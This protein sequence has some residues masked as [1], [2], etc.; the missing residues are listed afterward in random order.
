[1]IDN[2]Q[3]MFGSAD[4]SG[5]R[6]LRRAGMLRQTPS[7]LLVGYLGRHPI[8]YDGAG[9]LILVGGARSGKL[10]DILAYNI[11]AGIHTPA[12]VL[13]DPKGEL[14]A[15]GQNQ[16]PDRKFIIYWNPDGLHGLP[17][18]RINPVDY[19]RAGSRTLF[20]DTKVFCENMIPLSGSGN[21]DYFLGRAQEFL[22]AIVLTLVH[23]NGRA[24]LKDI[25]A[26]INLIPGGG[27]EWLDFAYEM[28]SSGIPIC[29]RIEEEIATSRDD[30]TGGFRGIMGELFRA[31]AC[32]S[33][34]QLMASVSE[35]FDYKLSQL[36]ESEQTYQLSLMPPA[37]TIDV[38]SPVIK[39][40]F[41]GA[42]IHKSRAPSAPRQTWII[43]EAALLGRFPLL[44][45]LFTF[46]AGIGIR[47]WAIFQSSY[48][49]RA[50]GKDAENIITS[51]A[52]L[53]SYFGVRD[54]ET[55]TSVSKMIGAQ[56][57]EYFDGGQALRTQFAKRQAMHALLSGQDPMS[58]ALQYAQA[59][60]ESKTPQLKERALR[61][62]DEII[63]TPADKQFIFTDDLPKPLYA[64]RR[65]YF[66]QRFMDGR[67][68]PSPYHPPRDRVRVK[69]FWG[70]AWRTVIVEPVPKR[71]AHYPQYQDGYWSRIGG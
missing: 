63:N 9:G 12:T 8:W 48:Q 52:Q 32:L 49:M 33:D 29:V 45:K 51:S 4:F 19:L 44:V 40:F 18:H 16:T 62:P 5:P 56:T 41:V 43:D 1:M 50:L 23:L 28:A 31:F 10:R 68:H 65:A 38:W 58:A 67:F 7:S 57:L 47:P 53:R 66:E 22:E 3:H 69:T 54:I 20:A 36:C 26:V 60:R 27:E 2:S 34:P 35:P 70:H 59:A 30:S 11:C 15:I 6:D 39:S 24:T 61:T 14:S 25:Y 42:M 21:R 13:L 71:F 37:E 55:G 64:D 17:M 46:G